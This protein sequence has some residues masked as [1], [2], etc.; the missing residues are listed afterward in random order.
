MVSLAFGRNAS[1][2]PTVTF[3]VLTPLPA[4]MTAGQT[5]DFVIEVTSDTEYISVMAQPSEFYPGR[6]VTAQDVYE[7]AKDVLRHRIVLTYQA[8]AEGVTADTVLN[9][10]ISATQLP[11]V[12]FRGEA[13]A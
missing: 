6:Y 10:V 13:T 3:N 2:A 8:L 12:E 7:L 5:Y 11:R 1:A 9:S 4:T